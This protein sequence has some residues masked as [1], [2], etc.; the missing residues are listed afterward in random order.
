MENVPPVYTYTKC[1]GDFKV[2]LDH[3][4]LETIKRLPIQRN[5]KGFLPKP[6]R[7]CRYCGRKQPEATFNK[8]AHVMPKFI[9]NIHWVCDWECDECNSTFATFE[10]SLAAYTGLM[11]TVTALSRNYHIPDHKVPNCPVTAEKISTDMDQNVVCFSFSEEIIRDGKNTIIPFQ[12]ES[13]VPIRI[14]KILLKMAFAILDPSELENYRHTLK[15]L[16][17]DINNEYFRQFAKVHVSHHAYISDPLFYMFKRCRPEDN[18]P[19]H[20]FMFCYEDSIF[21]ISLPY[22]LNDEPLYK[23]HKPIN[24]LFCPPIF[25]QPP[26]EE[27]TLTATIRDFSSNDKVKEKGKLKLH[28]QP[29]E[30][31]SPEGKNNPLNNPTLDSYAR[32]N[33]GTSKLFITVRKPKR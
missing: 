9:G 6:Q 8:T 15:F 21:Q 13:Y 10:T 17:S 3:Y 5:T 32:N 12:K 19:M 14:F 24:L 30:S 16:V 22:H 26:L 1:V 4:G 25:F 29:N 33:P 28:W 23:A 2:F 20:I 31:T 18:L 27:S 11:R 7:S